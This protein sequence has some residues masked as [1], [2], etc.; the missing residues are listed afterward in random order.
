MNKR[1]AIGHMCGEIAKLIY[2]ALKTGQKYNPKKH[3]QS[4]GIPW[5]S[6]FDKRTK[7][8]N[9]EKFHQ[10]ATELAGESIS[11]DVEII[12]T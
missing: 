12:E 2:M 5:D 3:A 6:V 7:N 1:T 10:E 4:S 9:L 8:V 11:D